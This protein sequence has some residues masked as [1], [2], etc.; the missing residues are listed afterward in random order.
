MNI[1]VC[2]KRVP[3]TQDVDLKIDASGKAIDKSRLVYLINE[4]DSYAAEE[5]V[6]LKEKFGGTVTVVTIGAKGDE[7]VLRKVLAMG[8]D[9][10]VRIDPGDRALDGAVI[11][12]ILATVVKQTECDLALTG[13]QADDLNEGVVGSMLA[14][15]LGVA[16]AAVVNGLE[17]EGDGPAKVKVELEGGIDEVFQLQLPAVLTIQSGINEPRYVSIMAVRK[18]AKKEMKVM[19]LDEL[20]LSEDDLT[21]H[22]VIEEMYL[23]SETG[24]AEM[25]E[26]APG[27]V[28]E[29]LYT[30]MKEKGVVE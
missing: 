24:G 16:H 10:A 17:M 2:V 20:G 9:R 23:P 19:G 28:A 3:L 22:T 14:G 11:S 5:A 25:I 18:A 30:I 7:E 4:W 1:M 15:H 21:P 26:G 12:K 13:V 8:A 6:L 27:D 29:A